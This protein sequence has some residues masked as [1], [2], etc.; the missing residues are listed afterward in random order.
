MS[1]SSLRSVSYREIA[2]QIAARLAAS[3]AGVD[4]LAPWTEEVVVA[5]GG[6]ANAITRELLA[7]IPNGIA[8]LHLQTLE[9]L[10]RRIVNAAGE[11]PRVASEG[12]RRLAMRTAVRLVDDAMLESRGIAAMLE[13]SYRDVRDSGFTLRTFERRVHSVERSLRSARRTRTIIEVW[14]SYERLISRLGAID[15]ADLLER[16]AALPKLKPQIVAGFYDMTGVQRKLI[17]SLAPPLTFVPLVGGQAPSPLLTEYDTK[18][19]ELES[20]CDDVRRLLDEGVRPDTIGITARSIDAYDARLINRFAAARGFGTTLA[21]ETPLI[22]HRIG[23]AL[24]SLLRIRERGFPRAEVLE[25]VRDGVRTKT[26]ID[27]DKSDADTRRARIAAGTSAELRLVRRNSRALDDY[28]NVVAEIEALTELSAV[29]LLSAPLFAIETDV[30]LAALDEVAAVAEI[31]RRAMAWNIRFDNA[32]VIDAL[33]QRTLGTGEGACRTQVFLGDV[34]KFRGRSFE[35]LFVVRAQDDLFPQRRVE[36]PLI[37]DSDRRALSLREIGTGRDEEQLLFDLVL[38]GP[39]V[40]VSY[41][42]SDGFGKVLRKSRFVKQLPVTSYRLSAGNRQPATGNSNTRQLQLLTRTGTN[43]VFDGHIPSLAHLFRDKLAAVSPTQLEDF[44]ECPQK[45][46]LKHVLGVVDIDDPERE[47]QINHRDKGSL[48][49]RILERFYRTLSANDIMEAAASLPLLPPSITSR[50]GSLI[51]T[52]FDEL[53]RQA[54]PFNR[55]MRDIERTATKRILRDFVAADFADLADRQLL[56]KYFEYRFGAK[57]ASRGQVDHPE[58]F[59]INAAG[60]PIRVE[61]QIDRIDVGLAPTSVP[62]QSSASRLRIVDYKSGKALRHQK[63]GDKIDR[64]V[65]LQLAMYAMAAA[66]FL[67]IEEVSGAIK[68]LVAGPRASLF[69]FNLVE[70][71]SGIVETLGIFAAAIAAGRFPAFPNER[72]EEFNSCKYCPVNHSCRTKHEPDERYA[73][74]QKKDPRTLLQETW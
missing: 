60:M 25:L 49:H 16:A 39:D 6:M 3:R 37:P 34:M 1:P 24:V 2:T 38:D 8:G 45:F 72:D 63:L 68:P 71:Y 47:L 65:R 4:P 36:D 48:D 13:R 30:D 19:A 32:A 33:E 54:P 26:R 46:L 52:E 17:E 9:T 7:R 43:S 27:V 42:S 28:M 53:E 73:V 31:F 44:G 66:R 5:S 20:I 58:P 22:A 69:E 67:D 10:A 35:H 40:R 41:A 12:E 64:G 11:F 18:H 51:D 70:K 23:R 21:E 14:Y 55:T 57:Y 61:G 74:G 29:E 50:L 62:G 15:P 56:P 59:T